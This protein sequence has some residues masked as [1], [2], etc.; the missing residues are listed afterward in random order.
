M[1]Y[2]EDGVIAV[3]RGD[4]AVLEVAIHTTDGED[5]AM[6]PDDTLTLTVR[7]L[8]SDTQPVLLAMVSAPGSRRLALRGADTSG[9]APGRYSCDIQLKCA[10][11]RRYTVFPASEPGNVR[12]G[13]W[14]NFIILPEVT[15]P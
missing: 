3:T 8:P 4:D 5:Y 9:I 15:V 7:A 6:D 14:E 13:N 1:L 10:D 2:I 12:F 11:G